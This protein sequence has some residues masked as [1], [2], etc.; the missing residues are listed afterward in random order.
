MS[1]HIV[2]ILHKLFYVPG[3]SQDNPGM[4]TLYTYSAIMLD[5]L[6]NVDIPECPLLSMLS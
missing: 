4:S 1:M 6:Y 3:K 2:Y 5:T